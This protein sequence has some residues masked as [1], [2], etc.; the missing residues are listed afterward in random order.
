[1]ELDLKKWWHKASHNG[2]TADPTLTLSGLD[3]VEVLPG[4]KSLAQYWAI[5]ARAF[6]QN[7][8]AEYYADIEQNGG[9]FV[10]PLWRRWMGYWNGEAVA[11]ISLSLRMA[12]A[13]TAFIYDV[14]TLEHARRKG[15]A[16][17]MLTTALKEAYQTHRIDK[18][19]LQGEPDGVGIYEKQGFVPQCEIEIYEYVKWP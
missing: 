13:K 14:A 18:V 9:A 3:I 11:T 15:F 10:K 19:A 6:L 12:D 5:V 16:S 1:M 4:S 2:T 7:E 17:Q 8:E